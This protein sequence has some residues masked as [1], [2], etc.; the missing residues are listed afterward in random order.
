MSQGSDQQPENKAEVAQSDTQSEQTAAD[1]T[2]RPGQDI[3][4]SQNTL[5]DVRRPEILPDEMFRGA[6][7]T[8]Q[9][10]QSGERLPQA[11]TPEAIVRQMPYIRQHQQRLET[12]VQDMFKALS[13]EGGAGG[14]ME[15][16]KRSVSEI[17]RLLPPEKRQLFGQ[18]A[19]RLD[20][21]TRGEQNPEQQRQLKEL[22]E[23][24]KILERAPGFMRGNLALAMYQ[25]AGQATDPTEMRTRLNEAQRTMQDTVQN[26]PALSEDPNFRNRAQAIDQ[27]YGEKLKSAA[28]P[29]DGGEVHTGIM[30]RVQ[31]LSQAVREGRLPLQYNPERQQTQ[32]QTQ[33][34]PEGSKQV[35]RPI[36]RIP[37]AEVRP[38]AE[39]RPGSEQRPD[40]QVS[41]QAIEKGEQAL[42]R[43]RQGLEEQMR[44]GVAADQAARAALTP[45]I[46]RS[47][48][49]SIA[50]ADA[51]P[52]PNG[53]AHA[54][55]AQLLAAQ[56][57]LEQQTPVEVNG[58]RITWAQAHQ[59][60]RQGTEQFV[61][62]LQLNNEQKRALGAQISSLDDARTPQ[63]YAERLNILQQFINS[64]EAMK[65]ILSDARFQGILQSHRSLLTPMFPHLQNLA[66]AERQALADDSRGYNRIMFGIA[67][68]QAGQTDQA[69]RHLTDAYAR[70]INQA[71]RMEAADNAVRLGVQPQALVDAAL[72]QHESQPGDQRQARSN[73][74]AAPP[75][76]ELIE[77]T[78]RLFAAAVQRGA[79]GQPPDIR[80]AA[81][82]E[83]T[84][85]GPLF[86]RLG[87][88][89]TA[90][91]TRVEQMEQPILAD[92]RSQFANILQGRGQQGQEI[93][94]L[95]QR[96]FG[97]M[98]DP[99]HINLAGT[100][101]QNIDEASKNQVRAE[102]QRNY[103]DGW[104]REFD[105]WRN[106][107]QDKA[108]PLLAQESRKTTYY[109]G[110]QNSQMEQF[111]ARRVYAEN[112]SVAGNNEAAK[113]QLSQALRDA[114]NTIQG[115]AAANP[116]FQALAR[117]LGVDMSP[118]ASRINQAPSREQAI[119]GQDR[120]LQSLP[121]QPQ[122]V[123]LDPRFANVDNRAL[124]ERQ[125]SLISNSPNGQ[126]NIELIQRN[127]A[128]VRPMYDELIRRSETIP[129]PDNPNV[130]IR[131]TVEQIFD[132]IKN[133][134]EILKANVDPTTQR[135]LTEMQRVQMYQQVLGSMEGI[136]LSIMARQD[137]A[138]T[139]TI[140]GQMQDAERI[141][142]EAK[143]LADRVPRALVNEIYAMTDR[144]VADPTII[145]NAPIPGTNVN[146]AD[147]LRE[148]LARLRGLSPNDD[149]ANL[150]IATRVALGKFYLGPAAGQHDTTG[151]AVL[152][153]GN[154]AGIRPDL[155]VQNL[156]EAKNLLQTDRNVNILDRTKYMQDTNLAT[157]L[158]LA[159]ELLPSNLTRRLGMTDSTTSVLSN[160]G[161]AATGLLVMGLT[162]R[163][164][165]FE[166]PAA[167]RVVTALG[168]PI[169]V[170]AGT[171]AAFGE[172]EDLMTSTRNALASTFAASVGYKLM[173][174]GEQANFGLFEGLPG[175]QAAVRMRT[176][177]TNRF[178][179]QT[180]RTR[181]TSWIN[182]LGQPLDNL[183]GVPHAQVAER[184]G[185]SAKSYLEALEMQI[186]PSQRH[187]LQPL[188]ELVEAS[189]TARFSDI[190]AQ[191]HFSPARAVTGLD[192]RMVA[193]LE[194]H[195]SVSATQ[196]QN[197]LDDFLGKL[198]TA[199]KN[200]LGANLN[201]LQTLAREN[202]NAVVML[203]GTAIRVGIPGRA[204]VE[205]AFAGLTHE[206]AA[207][208]IAHLNRGDYRAVQLAQTI[209][210]HHM[211]W[212]RF[213]TMADL[214]AF[215][216]RARQ[217]LVELSDALKRAGPA[218]KTPGPTP[219]PVPGPGLEPAAGP[220]SLQNMVDGPLN[221]GRRM[222]ERFTSGSEP[223]VDA[224]KRAGVA[225]DDLARLQQTA[226]MFNLRTP[227]Q[228]DR[229]VARNLAGTEEQMAQNLFPHAFQRGF[230]ISDDLAAASLR[231][232]R[233]FDGEMGQ[234][235]LNRIPQAERAAFQNASIWSRQIPASEMQ[236]FERGLARA[237]NGSAI[238]TLKELK[239]VY[240]ESF[241]GLNR[242]REAGVGGRTIADTELLTA[243][244]P[245][246]AQAVARVN[247]MGITNYG[248]LRALF[249]S[250]P[251]QFTEASF[252]HF[253]PQVG[254]ADATSTL[255]SLV[256]NNPQ[257]L[258]GEGFNLMTGAFNAGQRQALGVASVLSDN[259]TINNGLLLDRLRAANIQTINEFQTSVGSSVRHH[260]TKL[261][262]ALESGAQPS[263]FQNQLAAA[264]DRT[265]QEA[266]NLLNEFRGQAFNQHAMEK[267]FPTLSN[268]RAPGGELLR[269]LERTGQLHLQT[270]Q[271]IGR[272]QITAAVREQQR[273]LFA[274]AVEQTPNSFSG[275]GLHLLRQP[276][277]ALS[278]GTS[279]YSVNLHGDNGA[280]LLNAPA[281]E[282][283]IANLRAGARN[284]FD[285]QV[286]RLQDY[287]RLSPLN[288]ENAS[289]AQIMRGQSTPAYYAG[290]ATL[291]TYR[292]FVT[293]PNNMEAG[294]SFARAMYNAHFPGGTGN[295]LFDMAFST[296]I[297]AAMVPTLMR[298]GIFPTEQRFLQLMR[299]N[300]FTGVNN[301]L[302]PHLSGA[303]QSTAPYAGF[304][305]GAT[306]LAAPLY[307]Q[308]V[309]SAFTALGRML[310]G[311][312]VPL[313][314]SDLVPMYVRTRRDGY[315][316][317]S[318]NGT[319]TSLEDYRRQ[320]GIP[321]PEPQ[322]V[323]PTERP[324]RR[325]NEGPDV[326]RASEVAP[327][328]N[329]VDQVTDT[330]T[331]A[332]E[333]RVVPTDA[334]D[335][336]RLEARTEN[337]AQLPAEWNAHLGALQTVTVAMQRV[338]E[339]TFLMHLHEA[340]G[341]I[342][343]LASGQQ[344]Q[345]G[346]QQLARTAQVLQMVASNPQ[347][348]QNQ[349]LIAAITQVNQ[350]LATAA[351]SG[352]P[353]DVPRIQAALQTVN[354]SVRQFQMSEAQIG[355]LRAASTQAMNEARTVASRYQ[356]ANSP[357]AN[358]LLSQQG[359]VEARIQSLTQEIFGQAT[360]SAGITP[361]ML[362]ARETHAKMG[363]LRTAIAMSELLSNMRHAQALLAM[364]SSVANQQG[365]V[366]ASSE[367]TPEMLAGTTTDARADQ[368]QNNQAL[369]AYSDFV[370]AT[371]S[372]D[373]NA[374]AEAR[375]LAD[376]VTPD[377]QRL[378]GSDQ[379]SQEI[380]RL[381][382]QAAGQGDTDAAY[383]S[384]R[385]AARL[386]DN[387]NIGS[388]A[389]R[390]VN[391]ANPE[392]SAALQMQAHIAGIA[393]LRYAQMAYRRQDFGEAQAY[394]IKARAQYGNQLEAMLQPNTYLD[395]GLD[396][397]QFLSGAF[398]Q[399]RSQGYD[400][401][402]MGTSLTNFFAAL[403]DG[404]LG[405]TT[406]SGTPGAQALLGQVRDA[407]NSKK[408]AVERSLQPLREQESQLRARLQALGVPFEQRQQ[409]LQNEQNKTSEK[410]LQVE[411]ISRE[412]EMIDAT[413]NVRNREIQFDY[414]RMRLA[415]GLY[416]AAQGNYASANQILREVKTNSPEL[417]N[418]RD[419]DLDGKIALTESGL[420][421]FWNRNWRSVGLFT[422]GLAAAVTGMVISASVIGAPV[423][424]T[425]ASAG[426]ALMMSAAGGYVVG[427][428]VNAAFNRAVTGEWAGFHE[429]G[430]EGIVAGLLAPIGIG[431]RLVT[432][433]IPRATG[434]LAGP[435]NTLRPAAV[436]I[437]AGMG[438]SAYD[439]SRNFS[440]KS[441]STAALEFG[442]RTALYS[443]MLHFGSNGRILPGA[444]RFVPGADFRI[445]SQFIPSKIT[446]YAANVEAA[447]IGQHAAMARQMF[448]GANLNLT[449][450][451]IMRSSIWGAP[452]YVYSVDLSRALSNSVMK[453][454]DSGSDLF[455]R[456]AGTQNTGGARYMVGDGEG[457]L[458]PLAAGIYNWNG[459]GLNPNDARD[460][461]WMVRN[462][463]QVIRTG[464]TFWSLQQR[465][466]NAQNF[467]PSSSYG[468]L[469]RR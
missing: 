305:A 30:D 107:A 70:T 263:A 252:A 361:Q 384:L 403:K 385:Q 465:G 25:W 121:G 69:K 356:T 158:A 371:T 46:I 297:A 341:T 467:V 383:Q 452:A 154:R 201:R 410:Y 379:N 296:P 24:L 218:P 4:L 227:A 295:P 427:G 228:I 417:A 390:L 208:T 178:L 165:F 185:Q 401:A 241:K 353:V 159:N 147:V 130:L 440:E 431:S 112:L 31:K 323:Q 233:L 256:K 71:L 374:T 190:I 308:S 363:D 135:P 229:F 338:Q 127:I 210:G 322:T 7:P 344:V 292:T 433:L 188:R 320:R 453:G 148:S 39:Q 435:L 345:G 243:A 254:T 348:A 62:G 235:I 151:G 103:G 203:D 172:R 212:G 454:M 289:L 404:N 309:P 66:T 225:G 174:R 105:Q 207:A 343:A 397:E 91:R 277:F 164:Q 232:P 27:Q 302:R 333:R 375:A 123:A 247:A 392:S 61:A 209:G 109:A 181:Y 451:E 142:N 169:A 35:L 409:F 29:Q 139:L 88:V 116:Q 132:G 450:R 128:E 195:M 364:Q 312:G 19:R 372:R 441:W 365:V 34:G 270:G 113:A 12:M 171:M 26:Y 285:S 425:A 437:V 170:R 137:Y 346:Q 60:W 358:F 162:K 211:P 276:E 224:L 67:L 72:K 442:T 359:Q 280:G 238:S 458:S 182:N 251:N 220:L 87:R 167:A 44:R 469:L 138:H 399:I 73:S 120:V 92:I 122:A 47:F 180:A 13:P 316:N 23:N 219:G 58:Q 20:D 2:T 222:M 294:D 443:T 291:G 125:L 330:T 17:L 197:S 262:E 86:E 74:L 5:A 463:Y 65:P 432:P 176:D 395:Q 283:L 310:P 99:S 360:P 175:H 266:V 28:A 426:T 193:N 421:G 300:P 396:R 459:L 311:S 152:Q 14:N 284:T 258:S 124:R 299:Q 21:A 274:S 144:A 468:P 321:T 446:S 196:L 287:L 221:L 141:Y 187:L 303:I 255:A 298:P 412:M 253:F 350:A 414:N 84:T 217:N 428:A 457:L 57:A 307:L 192:A 153:Y 216:M 335:T 96:L 149:F 119:T 408:A 32:T 273:A 77:E 368:V 405:A 314:P 136:R 108:M 111:V 150:H 198:T 306:L 354:E 447:N 436:P 36:E 377:M 102:L 63:D 332:V 339:A 214:H 9:R 53:V 80:A 85:F 264:L 423:G 386:A 257:I 438:L 134:V 156:E 462:H 168:A 97:N 415:E 464:D 82:R 407:Y 351:T 18:W 6:R 269:N 376:V 271:A 331:Q 133:R 388:L 93:L 381:L 340:S 367:L 145:S 382:Q 1:N 213:N 191:P 166:M 369:S 100:L 347:L 249:T 56:R 163:G 246:E 267:L 52:P 439:T 324:P 183:T 272:E 215:G 79:T 370:T 337:A 11:D 234:Y 15:Q 146:R 261:K 184:M 42:T 434:A 89:A 189:P 448:S 278:R 416:D 430:K 400:P 319:Y 157:A 186:A 16:A 51:S 110:R 10:T 98:R 101:L 422:A 177:L 106:L 48:E 115:E 286:S 104:L 160:I 315:Q 245:A 43:Y 161:A 378:V 223:L 118:Y 76:G 424:L 281:P 290:L 325:A 419:L 398:T 38:G 313:S 420:R 95:Q 391:N 250:H 205:Q 83:M 117:Q 304:A 206:S 81:A 357:E 131:P 8:E 68:S 411:S 64:N 173:T 226:A 394:L 418:N 336:Q 129:H 279:R 50:A 143:A 240:Q 329:R 237:N 327:Q 33:A 126:K 59:G 259:V 342:Q 78:N 239:D 54:R 202:P 413:R 45:E 389:S 230:N 293:A 380:L 90:N 352:T 393:K 282:G 449:N 155:A 362:A 268:L 387:V 402:A 37:P 444:Q 355:Q 260:L 460:R 94:A 242:L 366:V 200:A 317:S 248:Q 204:A 318:I 466:F 334:S 231:N 301:W 140:A 445:G 41:S 199:D 406:D 455:H 456:M 326:Y 49:E 114:P 373:F 194:R 349:P 275:Q 461:A 3:T 179:E 40:T 288:I 429:G 244:F 75:V 22:A 55:V 328:T 236:V 265:P